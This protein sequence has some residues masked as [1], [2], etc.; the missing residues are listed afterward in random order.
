MRARS[1]EHVYDTTRVAL[2]PCTAP[3]HGAQSPVPLSMPGAGSSW[4]M[5]GVGRLPGVCAVV[6]GRSGVRGVGPSSNRAPPVPPSPPFPCTIHA[7]PSC[8]AGLP[9]ASGKPIAPPHTGAQKPAPPHGAAS[10]AAQRGAMCA[11]HTLKSMPIWFS[12]RD[13]RDVTTS[14][15]APAHQQ[16]HSVSV[17]GS[18]RVCD[19]CVQACAHLCCVQPARQG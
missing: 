16:G 4:V 11:L 8:I 5:R 18:K 3:E 10:G 12:S 9:P 7:R 19:L 1:G 14:K 2:D 17:C 15:S 6:G 13:A